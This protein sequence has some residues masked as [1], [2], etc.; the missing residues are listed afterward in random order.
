MS[1]S[2]K[3]KTTLSYV[4]YS[5]GEQALLFWSQFAWTAETQQDTVRCARVVLVLEC[6]VRAESF[7]V[8]DLK[9]A[10]PCVQ[11]SRSPLSCAGSYH[12]RAKIHTKGDLQSGF[13]FYDEEKVSHFLGRGGM[14]AGYTKG[15]LNNSSYSCYFFSERARDACRLSLNVMLYVPNSS[16][17][18]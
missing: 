1:P 5:S 2:Q 17:T 14:I 3:L 8:G 13:F 12:A 18:L 4:L 6:P 11:T 16:N 10:M 15:S 9:P 7:D